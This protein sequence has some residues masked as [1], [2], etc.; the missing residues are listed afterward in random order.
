MNPPKVPRSVSGSHSV[1]QEAV[2]TAEKSAQRTKFV[3]EVTTSDY[4]QNFDGDWWGL[5]LKSPNSSS[6]TP[7]SEIIT[8]VFTS[9]NVYNKSII[10][11][12]IEAKSALTEN[13]EPPIEQKQ[14]AERKTEILQQN[15]NIILGKN[16][17]VH[18]ILKGKRV[19]CFTKPS[20]DKN[21]IFG[22]CVC[23]SA[24]YRQN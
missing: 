8:E 14:E 7:V 24:S 10:I 15:Q 11:L 22:I 3:L 19:V 5:V 13:E 18:R 12:C 4:V 20:S 21:Y 6:P 16:L 1:V 17:P 23:F 2:K 9:D